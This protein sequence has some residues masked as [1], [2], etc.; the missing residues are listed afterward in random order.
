MVPTH[1]PQRCPAR[2]LRTR[3]APSRSVRP[4]GVT[5]WMRFFP[6]LRLVAFRHTPKS[7]RP[8]SVCERQMLQTISHMASG[9]RD[10][11]IL[12]RSSAVKYRRSAA[13][14]PS[15]RPACARA[16][17]GT[18][19]RPRSRTDAHRGARS[20][21]EAASGARA[22]C[23]RRKRQ[24]ARRLP[25]VL[26]LPGHRTRRGI[27]RRLYPRPGLVCVDA[28]SWATRCP[29]W[30]GSRRTGTSPPCAH[31]GTRRM[32]RKCPAGQRTVLT[33][34][35]RMRDG[36]DKHVKRTAGRIKPQDLVKL[37]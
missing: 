29:A 36:D 34:F 21:G 18:A 7:A 23:V 15:Q 13:T 27:A 35:D 25:V 9:P 5:V 28:R 24:A 17:G 1:A 31:C 37:Q 33:L 4:S 32:P 2:D 19:F 14:P 6:E 10:I 3:Q 12:F 26:R 22:A 16:G 11:R 20:H 30:H 8:G